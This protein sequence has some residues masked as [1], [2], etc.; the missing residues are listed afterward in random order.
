MLVEFFIFC[1]NKQTSICL[2]NDVDQISD[3]NL[4]NNGTESD[5]SE[6]TFSTTTIRANNDTPGILNWDWE[7]Y[8]MLM[9]SKLLITEKRTHTK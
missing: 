8:F 4:V 5:V 2:L 6:M 9:S 3:Q 7:Q 1:L